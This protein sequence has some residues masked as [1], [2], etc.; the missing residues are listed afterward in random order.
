MPKKN[1]TTYTWEGIEEEEVRSMAGYTIPIMMLSKS[2][3]EKCARI[4]FCF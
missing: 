4:I 2:V 1:A 3:G